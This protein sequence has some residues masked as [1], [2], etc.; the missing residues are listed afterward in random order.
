MIQSRNNLQMMAIVCAVTIGA[1]GMRASAGERGTSEWVHP[2]PDGK[3]VYKTTATGDRILDFSYAGYMG[4]GV[5]LPDVPVKKTIAPTGGADDTA[6]IQ[7]AIDEVAMLPL[8]D[9]GFRGAVLLGP[10]TFTC[11]DTIAIAASGVVLRGSGSGADSAGARTTIK[12]VG[13][14]RLAI[15]V[16]ESGAANSRAAG[17]AATQAAGA[18]AATQPAAEGNATQTVIADAYVPAGSMSFT[19]ADASGFA[20]GDTIAIRRPVTAAWVEFMQMHDL[21]RDG[22]PQTWIRVGNAT[23][24]ERRV[25]AVAG[26]MITVDVPIPDSFDARYLN[27]PGTAVVKIAPPT[28]VAQCGVE[29]LHILSPEQPFNHS[30]PH[31]TALRMNGQD[32]WARDLIIDETMDSVAVNGRR[33]TL[34]RIT[35]NRKADHP[36]ASKP[37]EFAPNGTQVLVDRCAVN[38]NNVWFAATGSGAAGPNVLLN[39]TFNGKGRAESHQ[40]WSTGLLYDNVRAPAGGIDFRNRGSM[41]SGHGWSMGWGV[42]WNC[43]AESYV[44]QHPPGAPN[45]MI[46]CIGESTPKP[47]P[48]GEGPMLPEGI[49]DSHGT[50]VAPQSLYLAQLAERLG[51]QALANIGYGDAQSLGD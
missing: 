15:A 4:G 25:A 8:D 32:C 20:P 33:I 50:P 27:P 13:T 14:P 23:T 38:A 49:K 1:A 51:P 44:I 39:C 12:L 3:L 45:W 46:G 6:A 36:G 41:G 11:A 16:R 2:G 31:F 35:V 34:R 18:A 37:A 24:T 42:A 5:P 22:K 29:S 17:G 40:R 9:K 10:G 28:R 47:R 43:R 26:S 30:Q 21:V 48:F 7:A 19:V